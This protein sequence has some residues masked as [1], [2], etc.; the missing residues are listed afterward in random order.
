[1]IRYRA[2]K[3]GRTAMINVAKV[4]NIF[5]NDFGVDGVS[6]LCKLPPNDRGQP[7]LTLASGLDADIADAVVV[8]IAEAVRKKESLVD[9]DALVRLAERAAWYGEQGV[10]PEEVA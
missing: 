4:Q 2:R 10:C 6:V 3:N 7:T 5:S 1:M 8:G 9:I